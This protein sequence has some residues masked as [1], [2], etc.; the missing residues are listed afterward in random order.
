MQAAE[1]RAEDDVGGDG[2]NVADSHCWWRKDVRTRER[3][4]RP[5]AR[6]ATRLGVYPTGDAAAEDPGN[7]LLGL[8]PPDPPNRPQISKLSAQNL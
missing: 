5:N 4:R 6:D 8:S 7:S 1:G 3:R 2:D